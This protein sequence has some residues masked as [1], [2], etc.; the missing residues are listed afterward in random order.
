MQLYVPF[1]NGKY[2]AGT[3][4]AHRLTMRLSHTLAVGGKSTI[5]NIEDN[6]KYSSFKNGT[7]TGESDTVQFEVVP[8]HH[9]LPIIPISVKSTYKKTAQKGLM[10]VI[11]TRKK[12]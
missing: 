11:V 6:E 5:H 8:E 3:R 10:K 1:A 12:L 7:S 9:N 2:G 4:C